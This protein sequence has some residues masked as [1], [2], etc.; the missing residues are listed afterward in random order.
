[1]NRTLITITL[2][3]VGIALAVWATRNLAAYRKA[4]TEA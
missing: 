2:V 1:M 3:L 4:T